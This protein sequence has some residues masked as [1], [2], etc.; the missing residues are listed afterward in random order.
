MLSRNQ[1]VVIL[2]ASVPAL[3]VVLMVLIFALEFLWP[4]PVIAFQRRDLK[5][6]KAFAEACDLVIKQHPLITNQSTKI[7]LTD[8]SLPKII[9]DLHPLRIWMVG[10]PPYVGMIDSSDEFGIEWGPDI[11]SGRPNVWQLTTTCE[12]HTRVA[13]ELQK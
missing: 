9:R 12:S 4:A 5:Y 2:L 8:P 3:C 11:D 13:Y 7:S 10:N 6:H 1:K